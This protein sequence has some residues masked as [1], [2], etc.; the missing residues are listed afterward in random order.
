MKRSPIRRKSRPR[1]RFP[2]RR[3][4]AYLI[5]IRS[6]A[7]VLAVR[8]PGGCCGHVEASHIRSRGAGGFDVANTVPLCHAHHAQQHAIGAKSFAVKHGV[9]LELMARAY[10]EIFG[11]DSP[12]V[13]GA[14]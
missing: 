2:K 13:P 5:L 7:C 12:A 8:D 6:A 10:A 3:D 1:S 9:D 4:P 14:A 11:Y